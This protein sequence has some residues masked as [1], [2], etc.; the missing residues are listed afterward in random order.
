[1][2]YVL[3]IATLLTLG[4]CSDGG[5]AGFDDPC[6][7]L[8]VPNQEAIL[9]ISGDFREE[10]VSQAELFSFIFTENINNVNVFDPSPT[11]FANCL[12][13]LLDQV[14]SP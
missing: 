5:I 13:S 1:M 7:W 9:E 2:R 14:Y 6:G 4:G 8:P 12:D 3:A 10:G 11:E